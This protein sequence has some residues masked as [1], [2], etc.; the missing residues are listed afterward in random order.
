MAHHID[1]SDTQLLNVLV[2]MVVPLRRE[3]GRQLDVAHFMH[4]FAYA[5]EVIEEALKSRDDRLLAYAS[6]VRDRLHGP[7]IATQPPATHAAPAATA[8]KPPAPAEPS[9]DEL[10][11]TLRANVLRKYTGG[12]R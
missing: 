2:R 11:A 4:D 12:L 7:R 9:T 5:R 10:E 3:F 8:P 6:Y 1:T